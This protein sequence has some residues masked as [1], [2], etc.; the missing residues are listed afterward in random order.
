MASRE[1]RRDL[2]LSDAEAFEARSA[3]LSGVY[4]RYHG[5]RVG[6]ERHHASAACEP[7]E[8]IAAYAAALLPSQCRC[9]VAQ[10]FELSL[11]E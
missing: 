10:R 4:H 6:V 8:H 1:Q 11:I 9:H 2:T 5:V 3:A 7:H